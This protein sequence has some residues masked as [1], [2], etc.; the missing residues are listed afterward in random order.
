MSKTATLIPSGTRLIFTNPDNLP[1]RIQLHLYE[2]TQ[3]ELVQVF[4]YFANE[5]EPYSE[6]LSFFNTREAALS[7]IGEL[8]PDFEQ[9]RV[10][11]NVHKF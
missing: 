10:E 1:E 3:G 8:Y 2:L 4:Y 6:S 9:S 7:R 11:T 5:A